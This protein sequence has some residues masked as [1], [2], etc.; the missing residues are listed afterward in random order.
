M[1][2]KKATLLVTNLSLALMLAISTWATPIA[3]AICSNCWEI[4][5]SANVGDTEQNILYGVAALEAN[6]V[7]AVGGYAD[8]PDQLPNL[9]LI[10]RWNGSTWSIISSPTNESISERYGVSRVP[11]IDTAS[12]DLWAVGYKGATSKVETSTRFPEL[13]DAKTFVLRSTDGG[14]TWNTVATPNPGTDSNV[15]TSVTAV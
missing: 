5:P 8:T 9:P 1:K 11:N 13:P 6:K 12:Q 7:V 4:V 10:A 15:L 3:E 2:L 14:L